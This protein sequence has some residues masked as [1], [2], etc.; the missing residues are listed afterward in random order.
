MVPI[1]S[2]SPVIEGQVGQSVEINCTSPY[3]NEAVNN[4]LEVYYSKGSVFVVFED[5]PSVRERLSRTDLGSV[6][7]YIF[8]PLMSSDNGNV[9]ACFF[10]GRRSQTTSSIIIICMFDS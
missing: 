6:T 4:I 3:P 7:I 9:L 1:I 8:G 10:Q 2:P 5:L